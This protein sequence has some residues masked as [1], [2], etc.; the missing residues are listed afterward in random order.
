MKKNLLLLALAAP[1][2]SQTATPGTVSNTS[3]VTATAGTLV[4]E[5]M[6]KEDNS[7]DYVCKSAGTTVNSGNVLPAVG[8]VGGVVISVSVAVDNITCTFRRPANEDRR[9]SCAANGTAASGVF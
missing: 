1:I 3:K 2:F 8:A 4:C 9:W 6:P 5:G 7:V